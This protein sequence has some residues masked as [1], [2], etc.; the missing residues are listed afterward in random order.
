[1]SPLTS[2]R[3][4][5]LAAAVV[6]IG[7]AGP[8]A[9]AFGQDADGGEGTPPSDE[10]V[11]SVLMNNW[12]DSIA[13]HYA[14]QLYDADLEEFGPYLAG[15]H[16]AG[17]WTVNQIDGATAFFTAQALDGEAAAGPE[18]PL[19]LCESSGAAAGDELPADTGGRHSYPSAMCFDDGGVLNVEYLRE[20]ERQLPIQIEKSYAMVPERRFM[21]VRYTLTNNIPPENAR[22]VRVR[23]AEVVDINNKAA[24]DHEEAEERLVETGRHQP[25]PSDPLN[26]VDARWHADLN[27]WIADMSASNGVFL[28]FGA[29]QDMDR[30]RAFRTVSDQLPFDRAI[31]S[32]MNAFDRSEVPENV[33]DLTSWDLGLSLW[34]EAVLDPASRQQYSFFYAVTGTLEEAQAVA[35]EA[36]AVSTPDE[37]FDQTAAAYG[38]WLQQGL[39]IA[40][41]DPGIVK[42]YTRALITSKHAQQPEFGSFVA[43]TNPAYGFKVWPR[44]SSV[45]A[46]GFAAAG[47]V[48]EAVKFYRWMAAVQE[49]GSQ[50]D[51]AAGTWF[52]NYS[53][54][55]RK[56][57]KRFVE[58]EWDSLG[59]F[60]I[61]VYHTW[62][63]LQAQDPQAAQDF[64]SAPLER[65]DQGPTSI[66]DAVSRAAEYIENNINEHGFG[67][68]DHSI[69]EEDLQ[70]ATFT[71]A[72]Y[73]SGLNAARLLAAASGDSAHAQE[74]DS[75]ARRILD[76]IHRPA[77]SQ[78]CPG[79]WHDGE[80]RW[81]RG[82]YPDCSRDD[83][84]DASSDLLWVFGLVDPADARADSQRQAVLSRLT[85]GEDDIGIGR[86]EGDQFYYENPFSPGGM[87]EAS[88]PLPSWP[89]MDMY[90]AMLEHWR[91]IDDPAAQRLTWY[92]KATNVGYMPPGEGVDWPTDRPLPSTAAEPV[93]AAWYQ[94]GLLN[95]LNLFDPRLPPLDATVSPEPI[96]T[97]P[98]PN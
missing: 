16:Y 51:F 44:D 13:I 89:Q 22:R 96:P 79:L 70:F 42:A 31:E 25:S 43:A 94:L 27:A 56:L 47:H 33:E 93:T 73:A 97:E 95:Q 62:R 64:L 60:M 57:P 71:Q 85:P 30:H 90:M 81:I 63:L 59:L 69:W 87:F 8:Y 67:P 58:P 74:W 49:D 80:S 21:V 11:R 72:T 20:T 48:D 45:T 6:L 4:A 92:A 76:A 61:G 38:A 36:R 52:S 41:T 14:R 40:A 98:I 1:M 3:M 86:Y 75:G 5:I 39:Q 53:Y 7:T 66:Y 88:Q 19:Q 35:Q 26:N 84:L 28:V 37:W 29:F 24:F 17:D 50:P 91:G 78:P 15:L 54:W 46:L 23:F 2:F 65:L 9:A 83:R 77:S 10:T 18:R 68:A 32:E 82:V 55:I 12:T 34:K